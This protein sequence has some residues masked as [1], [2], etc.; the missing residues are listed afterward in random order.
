[1]A[2]SMP[3]E[4]VKFFSFADVPAEAKRRAVAAC[5]SA[6][7]LRIAHFEGADATKIAGFESLHPKLQ[8]ALLRLP[9]YAAKRRRSR[10]E[11]ATSADAD[12]VAKRAR[13]DAACTAQ[14]ALRDGGPSRAAKLLAAFVDPKR[15]AKQWVAEANAQAMLGCAPRSLPSVRSGLRCW[16]AFVDAISEARCKWRHAGAAH[17]RRER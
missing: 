4:L 9:E 8:T 15:D 13:L 5:V 1:M 2:D 7:L 11:P 16:A 3:A 14:Q 6:D 17:T 10:K 12:A